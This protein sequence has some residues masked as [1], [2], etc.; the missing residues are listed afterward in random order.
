MEN[1]SNK[2]LAQEIKNQ[3]RPAP[4]IIPEGQFRFEPIAEMFDSPEENF[5]DY[6]LSSDLAADDVSGVN[7]YKAEIDKY[8]IGAMASLGVAVPSFASDTYNP[9]SQD[10]PADN[11]FSLIQKALTLEKKPISET[12]MAPIFSG[13][14]QGQFERY[15]NHPE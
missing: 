2:P 14:R 3:E 11:D 8:G 9:R 4:S 13:M 6:L 1:E 5:N 15:Y 7:E 10:Q 12:R